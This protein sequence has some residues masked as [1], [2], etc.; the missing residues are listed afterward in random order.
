MAMV[1]RQKAISHYYE[2]PSKCLF[3][4]EIIHIRVN[5][6]VAYVKRK[7]F[8]S[9]AHSTKFNFR[10][11]KIPVKQKKGRCRNCG[12]HIYSAVRLCSD[13]LKIKKDAFAARP[14][15]RHSWVRGNARAVL[16]K[17]EKICSRCGYS[18]FVEACHI[19]PISSFPKNTSVLIVNAESNLAWLCPNCH[20]ELDHAL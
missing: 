19:R 7:K 1:Q 17:R 18:K 13:C 10:I 9:I 16:S 3:C 8:C 12:T 15:S 5:E 4:S 14:I 2:N 11:G 20:W 6:A